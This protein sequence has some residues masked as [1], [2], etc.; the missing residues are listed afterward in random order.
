LLPV[1]N[2]TAI[3]A[4]AAI[5]NA[6]MKPMTTIAITPVMSKTIGNTKSD[7]RSV[8][9]VIPKE[10]QKFTSPLKNNGF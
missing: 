3:A 4:S 9:M 1:K 10:I 6:K 2:Q 5:G 8:G 7:V